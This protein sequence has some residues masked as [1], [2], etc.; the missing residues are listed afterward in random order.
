MGCFHG[1]SFLHILLL[2]SHILGCKISITLLGYSVLAVDMK[3]FFNR[4]T[5]ADAF[6][7]RLP[8]IIVYLSLT[9]VISGTL[10]LSPLILSAHSANAQ[11]N[12]CSN[13]NS[14][15]DKANTLYRT[16]PNLKAVV[17]DYTLSTNQRSGVVSYSD[18]TTGS[19][20]GQGQLVYSPQRTSI[21]GPARP[22]ILVPARFTS[23]QSG[24]NDFLFN[25]RTWTE[26]TNTPTLIQTQHPFSPFPSPRGPNPEKIALTIIPRL[27]GESYTVQVRSLTYRTSLSF[28]AHC[29][30]G[31]LYGVSNALGPSA[32]DA[33]WTLS[34][35]NVRATVTP[36]IH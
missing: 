2:S 27:G 34:I 8:T 9:V 17:A 20:L 23:S 15:F 10:V 29:L 24:G 33:L 14:I 5:K 32:P 6:F 18:S 30:A 31:I 28:E 25:D 7:P 22:P 12:D 36:I 35:Y 4:R 26:P 16:T 11:P 13:I 21:G 3:T 1:K 19:G